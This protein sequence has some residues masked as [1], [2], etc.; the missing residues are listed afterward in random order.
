[1]DEK[2]LNNK[3]TDSNDNNLENNNNILN[4]N[5]D[6][7]DE[8]SGLSPSINKPKKVKHHNISILKTNN[9]NNI[10]PDLNNTINSNNPNISN[11]KSNKLIKKKKK[12]LNMNMLPE[13][14]KIEYY[15][16]KKTSDL[17]LNPKH[18]QELSQIRSLSF[19]TNEENTWTR[20]LNSLYYLGVV[21]SL[22][23]IMV[24]GILGYRTYS[25]IYYYKNSNNNNTNNTVLSLFSDIPLFLYIIIMFYILM[26]CTSYKC[27]LIY[28][29]GILHKLIELDIFL[30]VV[31]IY[32]LFILT[33]FNFI[34]HTDRIILSSLINYKYIT[35][36]VF[37]I[38]LFLN[39]IIYYL[40]SRLSNYYNLIFIKSI[41]ENEYDGCDNNEMGYIW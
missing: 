14:Y 26:F 21:Y 29:S 1:M 38:G 11:N 19:V 8:Y 17:N 27:I 18:D 37:I 31:C 34:E 4:N 3:D 10:I 13:I 9:N 35:N 28:N 30:I 7:I 33:F 23:G 32:S 24:L 6:E 16:R 36:S 25:N 40:N 41:L 15:N 2:L 22:L 5:D 39:T 20:I 12:T